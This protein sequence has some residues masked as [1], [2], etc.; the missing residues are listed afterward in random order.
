MNK[1]FFVFIFLPLFSFSQTDSILT[2]NEYLGYVKKF[3]PIV[4]QA[5]LQTTESEIKLL[6]ARGAFDPKIE[7]DFNKK[8]FKEKEYYNKLNTAFKIPTWYG[9]EFKANYEKNSGIYLNP[10]SN[11]PDDGLY[12]V[13]VSMSLARGFLTNNRMATLKKSKNYIDLAQ[14]KQQLLTSEILYD[15][16]IVYF[17]W[18]KNYQVKLSYI[19]F[20]KNA[21]S[22]LSIVKKSFIEGDKAAID[23]LEASINLNARKLDLE[24]SNIKYLKSKLALSNYLW[25]ENNIPLEL[26]EVIIPNINTLESINYTLNLPKDTIISDVNNHSK[27]RS[28]AIKKDNLTIDKKLKLNNL[29]PKVDINYNFLSSYIEQI[30]D[31]KPVDYKAGLYV[32]IPL[33]L[34]KERA[35]YK[36]SKLK[37]QDIDF[38]I[39]ASKINLSNKIKGVFN[40]IE[41]YEKQFQILKN[42]VSDYERMVFAEERK[43]I[44][45]EGSLFLINYREVKLIETRLKLLDTQNNL[46]KSKASLYNFNTNLQ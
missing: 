16:L 2:L 27:I 26:K 44:L 35:D 42:L 23:T 38:S 17:N 18:L 10:E 41:S 30:P 33:F 34:R 31:F 12:N 20:L 6:K 40:E 14:A 3:H 7:V 29:L 46:L 22:R 9:I 24:K 32:Y 8:D 43:F 45:G 13:G 21:T 36:L 15:A 28:L 4:K 1:Y 5:Q 19:D 11:V 25:L 39:S 37:L